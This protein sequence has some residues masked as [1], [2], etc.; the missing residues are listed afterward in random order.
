MGHSNDEAFLK[1]Q[2]I[3]Y[4]VDSVHNHEHII[5]TNTKKHERQ[6]IVHG[7]H[8]LAQSESYS[9]SGHYRDGHAEQANRGLETATMDRTAISKHQVAIALNRDNCQEQKY[10]VGQEIVLEDVDESTNRKDLESYQR[11]VV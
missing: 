2:V 11:V 10:A 7:R 3:W 8:L 9:T 1:L 5:D 6:N 4:L